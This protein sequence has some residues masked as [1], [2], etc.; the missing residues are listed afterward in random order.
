[1]AGINPAEADPEKGGGMSAMN[2]EAWAEEG[3]QIEKDGRAAAWRIADWLLAGEK[4]FGD[5]RAYKEGQVIFKRGRQT[6][7]NL[8]STARA[9]P[10][11][12]RRETLSFA[13]HD[14][15]R[16]LP[17]EQ[18]EV[19]L[20]RAEKE[21]LSVAAFRKAVRPPKEKEPPTKPVLIPVE[22]YSDLRAA[23]KS[24]GISVNAM[25]VRIFRDYLKQPEVALK[26]GLRP[27][28]VN[29]A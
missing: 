21:R 1:M 18:Q 22:Q 23:A 15:V 13:H 28:V 19:L 9:F 26:A 29:A 5:A 12:R 3:R 16:A 4:E 11:S 10:I 27:V 2:L 14:E 25:A 20:N 24:Q 8:V 6:L 17:T 7:Y